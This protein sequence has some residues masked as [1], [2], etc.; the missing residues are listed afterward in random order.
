MYG[1]ACRTLEIPAS[2]I[3]VFHLNLDSFCFP[4]SFLLMCILEVDGSSTWV[5]SLLL[6]QLPSGG[7]A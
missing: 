7:A 5:S 3:K 2:S 4:P 6:I 1:L